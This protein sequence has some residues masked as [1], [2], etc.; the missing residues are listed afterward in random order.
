MQ[1]FKQEYEKL[2]KKYNLPSYENLDE[3]FELLYIAEICEISRPLSFVRRRINDKIGWVCNMLQSILQPN[4]SSLVSMQESA[5]FSKEQKEECQQ[6]LKELMYVNR[7]SVY[8][9]IDIEEKKNAEYIKTTFTLWK[10]MKPQ[11]SAIAQTLYQGWKENP[12][13]E[14]SPSN[15]YTG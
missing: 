13:K 7:L 12:K 1:D 6:L 4:P 2:I 5:M 10:K 8:L 9:D 3:E 15:N 14:H 11:I